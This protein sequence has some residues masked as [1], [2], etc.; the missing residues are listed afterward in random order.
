MDNRWTD[1]NTGKR[2]NEGCSGRSTHEHK[3]MGTLLTPGRP[4]GGSYSHLLLLLLLLTLVFL[5]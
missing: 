5:L 1:V 2:V 4:G 3:F